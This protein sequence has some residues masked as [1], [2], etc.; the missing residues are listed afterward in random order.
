[1]KALKIAGIV[2]AVL[3][4]IIIAIPFLINVNSFRPKLE[5]ALPRRSAVKLKSAI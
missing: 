4:L 1:M 5:S 2:V 3:L